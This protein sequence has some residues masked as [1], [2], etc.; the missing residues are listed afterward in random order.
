MPVP[1]G[2][3]VVVDRPERVEQVDRLSADPDI[4]WQ[5]VDLAGRR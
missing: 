4:A 5:I 3:C 2:L 1:K